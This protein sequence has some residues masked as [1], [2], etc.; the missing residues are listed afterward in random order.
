MD[1]GKQI[2]KQFSNMLDHLLEEFEGNLTQI[3]RRKEIKYGAAAEDP[4]VMSKFRQDVRS[5]FA[6]ATCRF[7]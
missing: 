6:S 3:Y 1:Q 4:E 5:I 7:L 2:A